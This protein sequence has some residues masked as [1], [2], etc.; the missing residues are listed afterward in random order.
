MFAFSSEG[1]KMENARDQCFQKQLELAMYEY[2]PLS[3]LAHQQRVDGFQQQFVSDYPK[4]PRMEWTARN[5]TGYP[6]SALNHVNYRV[7]QPHFNTA[8]NQLNHRVISSTGFP[9]SS[10]S[11]YVGKCKGFY[12]QKKCEFALPSSL[13]AGVCSG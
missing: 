9:T 8:E 2:P 6:A 10:E 3:T 7:P 13:V 12:C 4:R 11:T 5:S 1:G